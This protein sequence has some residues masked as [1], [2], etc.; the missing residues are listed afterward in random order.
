MV[1][2][3]AFCIIQFAFSCWHNKELPLLNK[4]KFC[5]FIFALCFSHSQLYNGNEALYTSSTFLTPAAIQQMAADASKLH[6]HINCKSESMAILDAYAR[7]RL[8]GNTAKSGFQNDFAYM[9]EI[10]P[11]KSGDHDLDIIYL[12]AQMTCWYSMTCQREWYR[13]LNHNFYLE[14]ITKQQVQGGRM[15]STLVICTITSEQQLSNELNYPPEPH[16][17]TNLWQ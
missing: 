13:S 5:F 16:L 10:S 1:K 3:L 4:I 17:V 14:A 15:E 8:S 9:T 7:R 11:S 12:C 2:I 6:W